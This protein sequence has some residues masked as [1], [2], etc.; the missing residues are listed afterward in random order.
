MSSDT[1]AAPKPGLRRGAF[2]LALRVARGF[3][4][5]GGMVLANAIAY[6]GLLSVVPLLLLA[7]ALFARLVERERFLHVV[8][9]EV[10]AIVPEDNAA[11]FID[12]PELLGM[13]AAA[14]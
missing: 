1:D 14:P 2:G 6:D 7:T 3:M 9:Q 11:P 5:N 13:C 4:R 10:L 12:A 8:R